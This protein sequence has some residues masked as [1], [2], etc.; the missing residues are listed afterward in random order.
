MLCQKFAWELNA[1]DHVFCRRIE[2]HAAGGEPFSVVCARC[3]DVHA[4]LVEAS[5]THRKLL[6]SSSIC[7]ECA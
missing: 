4:L 6:Q 3:C 1:K 7:G 5:H 2:V